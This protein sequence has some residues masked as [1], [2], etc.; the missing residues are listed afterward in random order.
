M[1]IDSINFGL[2]ALV[3]RRRL[4]RISNRLYSSPK[5]KINILLNNT[6]EARA[7]I[8]LILAHVFGERRYGESFNVE[9]GWVV[10]GRT[11]EILR[12]EEL[13]GL[14]AI[15]Q[16]RDATFAHE[17]HPIEL[18]EQVTRWLMNREYDRLA[19]LGQSFH[20]L[21]YRQCHERV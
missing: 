12:V 17:T 14:R 21:D 10:I 16:K 13:V 4:E 5:I 9:L 20:A 15:A 2:Y 1:T 6:K 3:E 7:Y 18:L 8:D 11:A 19:V